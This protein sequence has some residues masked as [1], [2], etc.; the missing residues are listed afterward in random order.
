LRKAE[1]ASIVFGNNFWVNIVDSLLDERW[2]SS[3]STASVGFQII[4]VGKFLAIVILDGS[5]SGFID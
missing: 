3:T 2:G 5:S 4:R 1:T